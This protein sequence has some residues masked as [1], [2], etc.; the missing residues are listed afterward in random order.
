MAFANDLKVESGALVVRVEEGGPAEAVGLRPGD[1]I[2]AFGGK[3]VT[4][5]HH[6]HALLADRKSGETVTITV[7]RDGQT[8]T[9]SPVLVENR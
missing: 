1:A 7:W 9:F 8:L 2:V 6:F 4:D 3:V 5:L